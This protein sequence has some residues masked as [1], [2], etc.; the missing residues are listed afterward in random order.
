MPVMTLATLAV[1]GVGLTVRRARP[2]DVPAVVALLESDPVARARGDYAD[3]VDPSVYQRAFDRI[4][5]DP[6]QLLVVADLPDVPVV[7]T[8]QLTWIPGLARGGTTR[9]QVE[10]VRVDEAHRSR[11]IGGALVRWACEEGERQG[12]SLVQ[13]T[14]DRTREQAHAFYSRLGFVAS[15]VGFKR[16]LG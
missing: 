12:A 7:A 6:A 14:S 13:L 5:A 11:G 1:D 16:R 10:A 15:H 4:D 8:M 3:P 2:A 9:L